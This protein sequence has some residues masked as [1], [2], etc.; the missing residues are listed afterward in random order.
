MLALKNGSA[1]EQ[2]NMRDVQIRYG[3]QCKKYREDMGRSCAQ[4]REMKKPSYSVDTCP[5]PTEIQAFLLRHSKTH[6]IFI[7]I[8]CFDT[9]H[10]YCL[11]KIHSTVDALLCTVHTMGAQL[12]NGLQWMPAT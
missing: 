10:F 8:S 7:A 4:K 3:A 11:K 2:V 6:N 1:L 12:Y 9:K 5:L